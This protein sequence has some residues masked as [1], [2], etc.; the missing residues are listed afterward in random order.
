M[1]GCMF[2]QQ[3]NGWLHV[4][5]IWRQRVPSSARTQEEVPRGILVGACAAKI[6]IDRKFR[7]RHCSGVSL[8]DI[9]IV[10]K[11]IY[12]MANWRSLFLRMAQFQIS[13]SEKARDSVSII[14][15]LKKA[16]R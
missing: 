7:K 12:G 10:A 4:Q 9:G 13:L 8:F 3:Y 5:Q 16:E 6:K 15:G 14:Y 11:P 1:N 2:Y